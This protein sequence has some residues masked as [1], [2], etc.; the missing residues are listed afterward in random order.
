MAGFTN[1]S[2]DHLDYH[3]SMA[4]Y[5]AAKLRLFSDVMI[6]G[7]TAVLNADAPEFLA[8]DAACRL[9]RHR[10]LSFGES[11][12]AIRLDDVTRE[13]AAQKLKLT[14]FGQSFDVRLPLT[15]RFQASNA[16]CALGLVLASGADPKAAVTALESLHGV[17]GRLEHVGDS[18]AGA[19]VYVD[20]AHT[21]DALE[22]V[23]AAL[24]PHAYGKL[25]VVFGCGGDR[26]KGKRRLMGEKAKEHADLVFV[27][28]DN[29]RT[30]PAATIRREILQGCPDA[31]EIG[32]RE[33]AIQTAIAALNAGDVLLI[34]GKGHEN[35]QIVGT[36]VIP[37]ND[38]DVA[39]DQLTRSPS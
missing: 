29:P 1:L 23:L 16:M 8:F 3:G 13:A 21:P 30:E 11:G 28:D 20:Y 24:R 12:D 2:Q 9:R 38:A 19:P 10:V 34:A 39:R 36:N 7:G 33:L 14:V 25:V 4:A 5:L 37:F 32:D 18:A 6:E 26:D 31:T 35:G 17:S 27:T 22:T 15:G